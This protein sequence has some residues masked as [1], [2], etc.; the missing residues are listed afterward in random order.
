MRWSGCA[1][2]PAEPFPLFPAAGSP[3]DK[4]AEVRAVRA[5]RV[6]TEPTTA[7][8]PL[9]VRR[10][11]ASAGPPPGGRLPPV[12]ER[13]WAALCAILRLVTVLDLAVVT[14]RIRHHTRPPP[15]IP[16]ATG[17]ASG[18]ETRPPSGDHGCAHERPG[19]APGGPRII[20]RSTLAGSPFIG[21]VWPEGTNP[22]RR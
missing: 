4:R 10:T 21:T 13:R 7:R 12:D 16:P 8:R 6:G 1:A 3:P 2:R 19:D 22:N 5:G 20:S 11:L 9:R 15:L 17:T 18:A 14:R